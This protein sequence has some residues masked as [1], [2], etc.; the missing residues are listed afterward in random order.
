MTRALRRGL[1]SHSDIFVPCTISPNLANPRLTG[2]DALRKRSA[3]VG[4]AESAKRIVRD[5]C[6]YRRR[7]TLR[8]D[9]HQKQHRM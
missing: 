7:H 8:T 6:A 9:H 3:R 4:C 1:F 2:S 5:W